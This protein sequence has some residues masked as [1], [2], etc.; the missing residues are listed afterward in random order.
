MKDYFARTGTTCETIA[1]YSILSSP[2]T[3]QIL[4]KSCCYRNSIRMGRTF[5]GSKLSVSDDMK[6][7]GLGSDITNI[8]YQTNSMLQR[9]SERGVLR[10]LEV[11]L[12]GYWRI[13]PQRD[14][15]PHSRVV[16]CHP[17]SPKGMRAFA[18]LSW[19]KNRGW[20]PSRTTMR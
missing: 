10:N 6:K 18:K 2:R 3:K 4:L 16:R 15:R 8:V 11:Y 9:R 17:G 1:V 7:T 12:L 5:L 13:E 14:I 20:L 19:T